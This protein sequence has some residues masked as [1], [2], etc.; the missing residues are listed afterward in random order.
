MSAVCPFFKKE[1]ERAILK[2]QSK[3]DENRRD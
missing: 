1:K 2:R 3:M